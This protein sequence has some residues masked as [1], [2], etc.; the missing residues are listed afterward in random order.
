[1]L[2]DSSS[3]FLSLRSI[4]EDRSKKYSRNLP[5]EEEKTHDLK[6]FKIYPPAPPINCRKYCNYFPICK[7]YCNYDKVFILSWIF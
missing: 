1:M 2:E 6:L 4:G 7:N 5:P 3:I